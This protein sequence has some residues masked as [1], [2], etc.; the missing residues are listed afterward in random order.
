MSTTKITIEVNRVIGTTAAAIGN[1][2]PHA[3][4]RRIADLP[5]PPAK[6]LA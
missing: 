1:A 3:T 4:G 2:V 6:L 5:V